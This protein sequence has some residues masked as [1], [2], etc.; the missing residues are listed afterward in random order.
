MPKEQDQLIQDAA[1]VPS[2][3]HSFAVFPVSETILKLLRLKCC[4]PCKLFTLTNAWRFCFEP[5]TVLGSEGTTGKSLP[6]FRTGVNKTIN[7]Y[8][9]TGSGG[10]GAIGKNGLRR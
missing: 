3:S 9:S 2:S 1:C 8:V 10:D 4:P 7:K 6:A 5:G